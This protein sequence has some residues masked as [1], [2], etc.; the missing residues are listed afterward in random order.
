MS[1]ESPGVRRGG[2]DTGPER[3]WVANRPERELERFPLEDPAGTVLISISAP[4][5]TVGLPNHFVGLHAILRLGFHDVDSK[6]LGAKGPI[7][8]CEWPLVWF[9]EIQAKEAAEFILEHR[10]KNIL[11]HCAAGVSRSGAFVEAILEAFPEYLDGGWARH[12]NGHV[13]A[14]LKRAL[15][16][17]PLGAEVALSEA[18]TLPR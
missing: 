1:E 9:S 15:G 10:G 17:V 16:L 4:L 6:H 18:G 3:P 14:L 5:V 13:K 11:V 2:L 12:P 7:L 8:G